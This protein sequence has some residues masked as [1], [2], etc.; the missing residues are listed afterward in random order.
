MVVRDLKDP[1]IGFVTVTHVD[2]SADL[3][4]ARVLVSVLGTEEAQQGTLQGLTSAAGYIRHEI[5]HRLKLRHAPELT[6]ALDHGT[7]ES[8]KIESLL[9]K[10]KQKQ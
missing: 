2:L 8:E 5:G 4:H 9:Q 6:F 7:E 3:R 10:L 1:R